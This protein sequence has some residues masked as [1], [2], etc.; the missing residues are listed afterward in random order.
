MIPKPGGVE[1]PLGIPT[2]SANC[3]GAQIRIWG[4]AEI[5]HP[6]RPLCGQRFEVLKARRI[7]GIDALLLREL[8]R[9][10]KTT[11]CMANLS[12]AN[13]HLRVSD[14]AI[15]QGDKPQVPQRAAGRKGGC[16]A[17]EVGPEETG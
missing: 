4:W 14:D 16:G 9:G 17:E 8:D 1:R 2:V 15:R 5:R 6:F 3:T 12:E 11:S 7:A 10:S 13:T